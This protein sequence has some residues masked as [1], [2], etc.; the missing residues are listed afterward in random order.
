VLTGLLDVIELVRR[1]LG[2]D[3]EEVNPEL[4]LYSRLWAMG[5]PCPNL[6]EYPRAPSGGTRHQRGTTAKSGKLCE[7]SSR[8]RS[9]LVAL[10]WALMWTKVTTRL[11]G[12]TRSESVWASRGPVITKTQRRPKGT[13]AKVPQAHFSPPPKADFG[14]SLCAVSYNGPNRRTER[15][16]AYV[17][18]RRRLR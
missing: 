14:L 10:G 9:A 7:I 2:A 17:L 3:I 13:L 5:A 6:A 1:S 8:P 12:T 15:E 4:V 16:R 18:F 11:E